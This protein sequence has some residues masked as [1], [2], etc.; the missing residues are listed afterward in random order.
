S[1]TPIGYLPLVDQFDTGDL[2]MEISDLE[3][4]LDVDRDRW[5]D[6]ARRQ[7]E[8]FSKFGNRLP[9]ALLDEQQNLMKRLSDLS[10]SAS[11]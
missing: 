9:K 8:F 10:V 7:T 11:S 3:K 2:A 6:A 4:I 5:L 1:R